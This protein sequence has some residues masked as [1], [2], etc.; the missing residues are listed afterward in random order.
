MINVTV[1]HLLLNKCYPWLTGT[2]AQFLSEMYHTEYK[3][4]KEFIDTNHIGYFD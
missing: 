2:H 3:N 4:L 1:G